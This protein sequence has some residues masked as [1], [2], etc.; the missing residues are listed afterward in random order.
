MIH[1]WY[2]NYL[3]I[4][5]RYC[6]QRLKWSIYNRLILHGHYVLRLTRYPVFLIF[7]DLLWVIQEILRLFFINGSSNYRISSSAQFWIQIELKIRWKWP[8]SSQK[9]AQTPNFLLLIFNHVKIESSNW[10]LIHKLIF[11]LNI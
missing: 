5:H 4:M 10:T 11:K 9:A 3:S 2:E 7:F 1:G 6:R 8:S